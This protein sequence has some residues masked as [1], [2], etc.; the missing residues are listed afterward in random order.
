VNA[1]SVEL[2]MQHVEELPVQPLDHVECIKV[3]VL[4]ARTPISLVRA[5]S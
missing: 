1:Q 3:C 5:K 4:H 2:T